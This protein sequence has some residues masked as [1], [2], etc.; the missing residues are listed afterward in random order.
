MKNKLVT[1]TFRK[2]IRENIG[3]DI[4]LVLAVVGVTL[5]S[6]IPPQILKTIIDSNLV[7][8]NQ[9]GLLNSAILYLTV[10]LVI[11]L[12]DFLKE[13]ILTVAGQKIT[14][15]IRLAMMEKMGRI[16]ARFF[17][18]NE[19]GTVVSRF[20]NDVDAVQTIFTSGIVGMFIDLL[21]MIGI[22]VSIWQ[23]SARLG[24]AALVLLPVLFV[25]TRVFQKRMLSAQ[26]RSR[27]LIGSINNHIAESVRNI[28]MIKSFSRE[29]YMEKRYEKY[30][31]SNYGTVEEI[32]FVNSIYP[33]LI[34]MIRSIVIAGII[35]FSAGKIQLS[36]LSLGMVAASIELMSNLFVP[37]ETLGMELQNVQE[38]MAGIRRVNEFY[39]NEEEDPKDAALTALGV[40]PDPAGVV[41]SF[42]D[43]SFAYDE[44]TRV[45]ENITL[46]IRPQESVTFI[47]RTGVGKTTLFRLVM[48]LIRPTGG[49]I[50]INGVDVADIPHSQK[51]RI[52]GYVEQE[53]HMIEGTVAD[54]IGL[55]DPSV[56]RGQIESA[57][58]M[59]GL[60]EYIASLESG[61]DTDI[62]RGAAFS[63]GQK[64]LLA[65]ARAVAANPPVL[66]LDEMT[67]NLDSI[68]EEKIV[69]A[70]RKV[71]QNHTIL[72]ISHRLSSMIASDTIVILENGRVRSAGSPEMLL[73]SDEW[74]RQ[75]IE[76]EKLTWR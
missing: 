64:Q 33:P 65:I 44:D 1:R 23:F 26:M 47:G 50:A 13:A 30:L 58:D 76:L 22:V 29:N 74:Y 16:D 70:L 20:T 15:G 71:S 57:V 55:K 56:S 66:L 11:G 17:S 52:F 8:Q 40:I 60:S 39:E 62:S 7:P 53:F 12:S 25:L 2:V 38:S 59:V 67:A 27:V 42:E 37:V 75:H 36:G 54:Q 43:V 10:L 6:L 4:L 72:S 18:R 73:A 68:T 46:T 51:R 9:A 3:L 34:Q 5:G 14:T 28:Q 31:N 45:L 63:Q 21:K 41:L 69:A 24:V 32:N 19:T 49:R 48:G 61:I 35:L